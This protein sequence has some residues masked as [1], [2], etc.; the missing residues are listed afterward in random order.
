MS[1]PVRGKNTEAAQLAIGTGAV[2]NAVSTSAAPSVA[3]AQADALKNNATSASGD[4]KQSTTITNK[5]T[6][7]PAASKPDEQ[8]QPNV[9]SDVLLRSQRACMKGGEAGA[10]AHIQAFPHTSRAFSYL[11]RSPAAAQSSGN[12]KVLDEAARTHAPTN[13]LES[14]PRDRL[15]SS[16]F[17]LNSLRHPTAAN[18]TSTS[19][20]A[21]PDR[22]TALS[23]S[24]EVVAQALQLDEVI[25]LLDTKQR[26]MDLKARIIY[27]CWGYEKDEGG[28]VDSSAYT[29][30]YFVITVDHDLSYYDRPEC[31]YQNQPKGTL[32]CLGMQCTGGDGKETIEGKECFTFTIQA[33]EE[34]ER[35]R[36]C[37]CE[38]MEARDKLLKQLTGTQFACFTQFTCFTGTSSGGRVVQALQL[39]EISLLDKL[40][41]GMS[42]YVSTRQHTSASAA[43]HPLS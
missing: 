7:K 23:T 36:L 40:L 3:G 28:L 21:T 33:K 37:A 8:R 39:D 19:L 38:T 6:P 27:E 26:E 2:N 29:K 13:V 32:S 5:A 12:P 22:A 18:R 24:A 11:L 41:P 4:P 1:S 17:S 16:V 30:R 25:S 31:Y 42:T 20:L 10:L 14:S 9:L 34:G 43:R 35:A 15:P